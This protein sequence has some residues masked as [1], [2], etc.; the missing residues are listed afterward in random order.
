MFAAR[1]Y[2]RWAERKGFR[3]TGADL[4]S[5][6]RRWTEIRN[7]CASKV[8]TPSDFS[9]TESGVHRLIRIFHST[10]AAR[11]A[12]RRSPDPSSFLKLTIEIDIVV[13]PRKCASTPF[14]AGRRRAARTLTTVETAVRITHLPS[15]SSCNARIERSQHKNVGGWPLKVLRSRL[16]ELGNLRKRQDGDTQAGMK[17]RPGHQCAAEPDSHIQ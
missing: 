16:Y 12:T 5:G 13:N 3:A 4:D 9:S 10:Q 14:R 11:A 17:P 6:R 7:A 8:R 1:M 15:G 2:L